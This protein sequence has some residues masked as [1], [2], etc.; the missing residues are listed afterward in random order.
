MSDRARITRRIALTGWLLLTV[1]I[2]CWPLGSSGIGWAIALLALLPLLLPLPGI[3]RGLRRSFGWAPLTLAPA[4]ALS[5]VEIL[6]NAAGRPRA[7][8]TLALALAAFAA[9]VAAL[10]AA[11]RT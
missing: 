4:L 9:L 3:A 6:V 8:L 10:R 5:L 1:S 11:P 2:A 7:T